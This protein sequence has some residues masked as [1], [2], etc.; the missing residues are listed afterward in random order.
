MHR[1][2]LEVGQEDEKGVLSSIDALIFSLK[3]FE[4]RLVGLIGKDERQFAK[5]QRND[6]RIAL[7]VFETFLLRFERDKTASQNGS[8]CHRRGKKDAGV[9][10]G[11]LANPEIS[12]NIVKSR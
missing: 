11:S 6:E 8:T 7:V 9:L 10:R 12:T 1:P 5:I 4:I 2:V 3:S